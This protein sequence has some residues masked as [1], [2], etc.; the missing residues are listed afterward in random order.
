[1][2]D[3]IALA[4]NIKGQM[5]I[6]KPLLK[7]TGNFDEASFLCTTRLCQELLSAQPDTAM[8]RLVQFGTMQAVAVLMHGVAHVQATNGS[9]YS[10][11]FAYLFRGL[12]DILSCLRTMQTRFESEAGCTISGLGVFDDSVRMQ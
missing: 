5:D 1:M 10:V 7:E 4:K 6:W 12:E 8:E 9:E 3:F 2:T 11:I